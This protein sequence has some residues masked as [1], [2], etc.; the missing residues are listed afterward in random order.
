[1]AKIF[2][3]Q[4]PALRDLFQQI[5]VHGQKL[6]GQKPR[7]GGRFSMQIPGVRGGM[8]MAKIDS[9]IIKKYVLS[10]YWKFCVWFI[11]FVGISAI[12]LLLAC[13]HIGHNTFISLSAYR[14]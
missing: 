6:A 5:P 11:V 7:S 8:I 2:Y 1:M 3:R 14:P 9:C 4:M 10:Y 13:R 12:I